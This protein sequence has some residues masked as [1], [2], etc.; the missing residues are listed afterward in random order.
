MVNYRRGDMMSPALPETV[1]ALHFVVE[2]LSDAIRERRR[3]V[4]CYMV[5]V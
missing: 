1:E 4:A 3:A 5:V 2:E